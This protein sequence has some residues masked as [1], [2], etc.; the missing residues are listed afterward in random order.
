MSQIS[1]RPRALAYSGGLNDRLLVAD[2]CAWEADAAIL[3][4]MSNNNSSIDNTSGR[5][6]QQERFNSQQVHGAHVAFRGLTVLREP[7]PS[8][9]LEYALHAHR[10]AQHQPRMPFS[11]P[12][13]LRPLPSR[14]P[15]LCSAP[16]WLSAAY[17]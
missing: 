1:D 11:T 9:L 3:E 4:W 8:C 15:D 2:R 5:A 16:C 6:L 14:P 10:P 7:L 12:S 17:Q 13:S